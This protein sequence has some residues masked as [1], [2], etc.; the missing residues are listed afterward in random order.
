MT[1]LGQLRRF[2]RWPTTSGLPRTT[3]IISPARLG[4][5]GANNDSVT[6]ANSIV[7]RS[8]RHRAVGLPMFE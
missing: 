7:V 5:L 2:D 6:A 4:P 3:D 1:G 8:P